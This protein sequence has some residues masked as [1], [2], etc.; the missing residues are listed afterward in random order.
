MFCDEP[1]TIFKEHNLHP[2]KEA[3]MGMKT[4]PIPMSMKNKAVR[5]KLNGGGMGWFRPS[6]NAMKIPVSHL[7]AQRNHLKALDWSHYLVLHQ[8]DTSKMLSRLSDAMTAPGTS[9]VPQRGMRK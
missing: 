6:Y 1:T 8:I 7:M 2:P 4:I 3:V 5:L 9:L